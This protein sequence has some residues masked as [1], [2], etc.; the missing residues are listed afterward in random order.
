MTEGFLP[1]QKW[2]RDCCITKSPPTMVTANKI[3]KCGAHSRTQ[4]RAAQQAAVSFSQF[5]FSEPAP[6]TSAALNLFQAI[7]CLESVFQQSFREYICWDW[8]GKWWLCVRYFQKLTSPIKMGDHL[9]AGYHTKGLWL[10]PFIGSQGSP[11]FWHDPPFYHWCC[12]RYPPLDGLF[13][14]QGQAFYSGL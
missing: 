4:R 8:G 6:G 11:L 14:P 3:R 13:S 12:L 9:S 2:L 10:K 5:S 7:W 1:E